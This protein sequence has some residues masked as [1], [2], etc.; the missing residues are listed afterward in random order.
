LSRSL[1]GGALKFAGGTPALNV[2]LM[3]KR[4]LFNSHFNNEFGANPQK[5]VFCESH[6][7]HTPFSCEYHQVLETE[8]CSGSFKLI[9]VL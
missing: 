7:D 1:F 3:T 2:L 6:A 5:K 4:N 8:V 9:Q